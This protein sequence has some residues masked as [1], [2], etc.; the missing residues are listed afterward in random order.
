MATGRDWSET[1]VE[2]A[3]AGALLGGSVLTFAG[4][5]RDAGATAAG[6]ATFAGAIEPTSLGVRERPVRFARR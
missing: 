3:G 1:V 2:L 5:A 4:L 6:A